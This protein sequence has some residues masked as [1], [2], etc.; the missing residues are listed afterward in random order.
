MAE[1]VTNLKNQILLHGD[2]I[3]QYI[4]INPEL[5]K[6]SSIENDVEKIALSINMLKKKY[7]ALISFPSTLILYPLKKRKSY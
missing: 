7:H 3:L 4:H 1:Q 2:T 6:Q 5:Q